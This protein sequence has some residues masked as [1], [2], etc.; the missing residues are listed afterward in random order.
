MRYT[1]NTLLGLQE[2]AQARSADLPASR[3]ETMIQTFCERH[4][5]AIDDRADLGMLLLLLSVQ[6]GG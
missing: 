5:D 4:G 3:V 6:S 2:A 1:L